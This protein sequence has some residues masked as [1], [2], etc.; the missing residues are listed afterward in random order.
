MQNR[1]LKIKNEIKKADIKTKIEKFPLV[2]K[3]TPKGERYINSKTNLMKIGI[4]SSIEMMIFYKLVIIVLAF[5]LLLS[6]DI[7]YINQQRKDFIYGVKTSINILNTTVV[8]DD[9]KDIEKQILIKTINIKP[10]YRK[11]LEQG[12]T[13]ELYKTIKSIENN[14]LIEDPNNKIAKDILNKIYD[15]YDISIKPMNIF[16]ILMFSILSSNLLNVYISLKL[17]F[18]NVRVDKEVD[19]LELLTFILIK[20]NNISVEEIL[21][22]QRDYSTVLKPCYETCLRIYPTNPEKALEILTNSVNNTDFNKFIYLVKSTLTTQRETN[23]ELID[24]HKNLRNKIIEERT[25]RKNSNKGLVF[26]ILALP[27]SLLAY[28]VLLMPILTYVS[29]SLK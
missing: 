18:L 1:L 28:M 27:L 17:L 21:K 15:L 4:K 6:L 16:Y 25:I 11:I 13:L 20:N 5:M 9:S 7:Y 26:S 2:K 14:D 19:L 29:S 23:V 3:L 12:N 22:K 8:S 24:A 10:N